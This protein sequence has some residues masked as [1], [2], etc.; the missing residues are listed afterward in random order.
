MRQIYVS[1]SHTGEAVAGA[2]DQR[3][4]NNIPFGILAVIHYA[5]SHNLR[6]IA[7]LAQLGDS[8]AVLCVRQIIAGLIVRKIGEVAVTIPERLHQRFRRTRF[9]ESNVAY[10]TVLLFI[11]KVKPCRR[12]E[13][14]L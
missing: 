1:F 5:L 13:M 3:V 7:H 10:H 8:D 12:V 6:R 9:V 2:G 11:H 14:I 4:I